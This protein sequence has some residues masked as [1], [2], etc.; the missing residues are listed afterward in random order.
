MRRLY[1]VGNNNGALAFGI[2]DVL[3]ADLY[4]GLGLDHLV[5]GQVVDDFGAIEGQLGSLRGRDGAE[6][7][8]GR[9]LGRVCREDSVDFLPDLQLIGLEAHGHERGAK[10]RVSSSDIAVHET[11]WHVAK[12]TCDHGDSRAACLYPLLEQR[13]GI[14]VKGGRK[15]IRA[16]VVHDIGKI[17]IFGFDVLGEESANLILRKNIV[18]RKHKIHTLSLNRYAMNLQLNFSPKLTTLSLDLALTSRLKRLAAMM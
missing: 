15:A 10:V 5:H 16:V 1:G 17:D 12:E 4:R 11:A 8:R 6:E 13:G 7:S 18:T 14:A 9:N 3:D 2:L